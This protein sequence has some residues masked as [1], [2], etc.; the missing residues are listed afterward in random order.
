MN[1]RR[2][3]YLSYL[4]PL[5]LLSV[6]FT[7]IDFEELELAFSEVDL[8]VAIFAFS[9]YLAI[10]PIITIRWKVLIGMVC[11]NP[12][13]Y[14]DALVDHWSGMATGWVTPSNLGWDAFRAVS[15][16]RR[17]GAP[18]KQVTVIILEKI[19]TL[20]VCVFLVI[21]LFSVIETSDDMST[22]IYVEKV[23]IPIM[24]L[25]I[26]SV[27]IVKSRAYPII[28]DVITNL[29]K[30]FFDKWFEDFNDDDRG[31]THI[32][33]ISFFPPALI[34]SFP[35]FILAIIDLVIIRSM[36]AEISIFETTFA[37]SI[38]AVIFAM[39]ISFGSL[40]VREGSYILIYSELGLTNEQ[41]LA[42]SIINLGG[43]ILNSSVGAIISKKSWTNHISL[44]R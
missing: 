1:N 11:D 2:L 17:V 22:T 9:A 34:S 29:E 18:R 37:V 6:V 28:V 33:Q 15:M 40:G 39:P 42:L 35:L 31:R 19:M 7:T 10:I 14:R 43:I 38:L 5:V 23:L 26:F 3:N 36:G 12:P 41:A 21:L 44:S 8:L 4:I 13:T 30:R 16:S 20:F 27:L 24:A 32:G 25:L